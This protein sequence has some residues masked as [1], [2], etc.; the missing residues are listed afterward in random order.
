MFVKL[1]IITSD[2][3][4]LPVQLHP[5]PYGSANVKPWRHRH[6]Y[7]PSVLTHVCWQQWLPV[8]HS[9]TSSHVRLSSCRLYQLTSYNAKWLFITLFNF[10]EN[11]FL[12]SLVLTF[13]NSVFCIWNYTVQILKK[14]SQSLR[15]K[16]SW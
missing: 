8:V 1:F 5:V 6:V 4:S 3:L 11:V 9:S 7:P 15:L 14:V 2:L 12:Y 16:Y 13:V 10:R